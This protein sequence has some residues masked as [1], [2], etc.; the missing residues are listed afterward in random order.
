MKICW[1]N[2]ENLTLTKNGTF[3]KPYRNGG[4][5][6]TYHY[7]EKCLN[8]AEPFLGVVN[9]TV[10]SHE[11]NLL[12]LKRSKEERKQIYYNYLYENRYIEREELWETDIMVD[13][14]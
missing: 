2:I 1:D 8:C 10:C 7:K 9:S 3:R 5:W 13:I 4:G 6:S 11:C 12:H 14:R